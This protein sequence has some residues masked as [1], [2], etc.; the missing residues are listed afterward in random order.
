MSTTRPLASDMTG[1]SR[2]ISGLTVPVT[3]NC[4]CVSIWSAVAR[5]KRSGL[6][7]LTRPALP[8]E[9]TWAGGGAPSDGLELLLQATS[10]RAVAR[11]EQDFR[12][13]LRIIE[14]P[15]APRLD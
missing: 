1:T 4:G 2:A 9:M 11:L 13:G 8:L 15:R 7:T 12:I 5:R 10:S 6:S 14:L 3:R